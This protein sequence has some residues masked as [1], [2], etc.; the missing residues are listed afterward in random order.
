MKNTTI[1]KFPF[2]VSDMVAIEMPK[3]AKVLR[4]DLQ[5]QP[6]VWALVN[7]ESEKVRRVFYIFGTGHSLG[8]RAND[9]QYIGT[10]FEG[11]FVW[12]VFE[13]KKETA[14]S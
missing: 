3:G 11:P 10:F 4:V 8:P 7:P 1:W 12:H 13:E 2:T 9:L 6:C 14:W 5:A